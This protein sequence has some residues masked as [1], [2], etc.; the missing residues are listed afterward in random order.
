MGRSCF[1]A[2]AFAISC[3]RILSKYDGFRD[4]KFSGKS[5]YSRLLFIKI[6]SRKNAKIGLS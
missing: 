2:A 6:L 5:H 4:Y 1:L 3:K